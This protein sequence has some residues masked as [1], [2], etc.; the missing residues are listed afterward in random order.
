MEITLSYGRMGLQ[1]TLPD[2]NVR[3]VLRSASLPVLEDPREATRQVLRG[4]VGCPPLRELAAGKADAC[5]VTSD[6]TRPVP[7]GAILPVVLEE[8]AA[9]EIPAERIVV[10]IATGSHRPN[11]PDE[12]REML[13]DEVMGSGARIV[14]HDAFDSQGLVYRGETRRGTPVHVNRLYAEA[15]VGVSVSL[16]E[17][18]L[19]A[20]FSGGR[21]QICPGICGIDTILHFHAPDLVLP[22]E[23]CAGLIDANPAHEES[24]EATRIAGAPEI[25]VNATLDEVRRVTGIFVG[26][27]QAAHRGAVARSVAAC[28]VSIPGPI[29]IA[30]TTG[31]G[32]PLDLTFYQSV[33]GL[34][35][36][37]PILKSGGTIIAACECAEGVGEP[38]LQRRIVEL[39]DFDAYQPRVWDPTYFHM[40][41]WHAQFS[42]IRRRAGEVLVFSGGISRPQLQQCFVTPVDSVEEAAERAL[43]AHG[44]DATIAVLPEGPYVLPCIEGDRIDRQ[45]FGPAG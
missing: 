15:D 41:Q 13:G 23:A 10:L 20:G 2:R 44:P 39:N 42:K 24:L 43:A 6:I 35:A 1:A 34:A 28:K 45:D 21:K 38:D 4:P 29:D 18:H 11:T 3:H 26:E 33:K 40:D 36:P 32:H 5:I 37:I 17:P 12:L 30:V 27:L 8:L 25:T 14:N 16:V 22:D 19:I 9:A 7:N 31:A